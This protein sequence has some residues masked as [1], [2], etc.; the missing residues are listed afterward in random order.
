M[1]RTNRWV[2]TAPTMVTPSHSGADRSQAG[3]EQ[4]DG[5]GHFHHAGHDAEPL[6]ES[7]L[8]EQVDHER[9]AGQFGEAGGKESRRDDTCNV[10]A[11]MRRVG[12]TDWMEAALILV[13]VACE[14]ESEENLRRRPAMATADLFR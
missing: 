12:R 8:L 7:D 11:P 1:C 9:N 4:R 10:Q 6:T 5:A 14:V 2:A 3:N 13:S